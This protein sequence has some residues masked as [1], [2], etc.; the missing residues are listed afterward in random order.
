MNPSVGFQV[1]RPVELGPAD[2]T[3]IGFLTCYPE[4]GKK[5]SYTQ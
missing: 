5:D 1:R 2:V 3:T 4:K